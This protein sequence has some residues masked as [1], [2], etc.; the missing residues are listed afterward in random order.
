MT[1]RLS[2]A[3]VRGFLV[4]SLTASAV[5]GQERP[6]PDVPRTIALLSAFDYSTRMNAARTLRRLPPAE[7][8]PAL[9]QAVRAHSD[10]FVRHRALVLLTSFNDR[11]TPDLMRG[12][13]SD[14]NDRVRE[15]AYR[16]FE[17]HPDRLLAPTL[18][19]ALETEQAE[20]V[21]PA[22]IRAL[23][24]LGHDTQVQRA[25]VAEAGRGLDFFRSAVIEALGVHRA[26]YAFD[27]IVPIARMEGS[28]QDDAVLALGRMG[29][30]RALEILSS[31]TG[32]RLEFVPA[33]HA[34]QCLLED[35]C[36]VHVGVLVDTARSR[37]ASANVTRAAVA[38]LGVV[39]SQGHAGATDALVALANDATGRLEDDVALAFS[40]AA[41]RV[42]DHV[43]GWL[44]RTA[45]PVRSRA[46]AL[47]RAGFEALE[48]DFAEERFFA[49]AR[50]AYWSEAEGSVTRTVTARLIDTLEF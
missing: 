48:E 5:T 28:L 8:V 27:A 39:V 31:L 13:L 22:L 35:A 15:T 16:W 46:F 47:L 1:A 18:L 29:D 32:P 20:F 12:L 36:A 44:A 42:P 2:R 9:A 43:I 4:A 23:A 25:L 11:G 37:A 7:V 50:A 33:I 40:G 17:P 6:A 24:A 14:R 38:A 21:R 19:A 30:R 10:Q 26:T 3:I 45:D 49:A 41:L 34:A